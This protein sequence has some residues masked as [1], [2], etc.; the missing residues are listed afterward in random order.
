MKNFIRLSLISS[1]IILLF[2]QCGENR[3][4]DEPMER[5]SEPQEQTDLAF[6]K[7]WETPEELTTCESV[8]FDENSGA[9]Y[10]ANINGDPSEKNGSGFI[11]K[12]SKEGE[13]LEHEWVSGLD[14]PKGMGILEGQ[15]YVTDID[16]VVQVDIASASISNTWT[17]EGAV[18]LNDL[19]VSNGKVYF[20][21]SSAGTIFVLDDGE[22]NTFA[23]G[24]EGINGLKADSD[25]NLYGLD[26]EG[27]K[28]YSSDGSSEI[29]NNVVTGGDG[30]IILDE[31]KGDF[32][33][34]RWQGE[35]WIIL[36]NDS[37]KLLDTKE[38]ESNTADIGYIPEDHL[39][40]V[41]TFF[42]NKVVAYR[43]DY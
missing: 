41:P 38:E 36:G 24:Q 25:G 39:I 10:V 28:K 20:S 13:I 15:L 27:L 35:I 37:V 9:I 26:N 19:D 40:I 34:S 32:L 14:A 3:N 21:D 1:L 42:K 4:T 5:T 22:I 18:F 31:N 23:E 8:L 7:L 33:V 17:V 11:S 16:K 30:L 6:T 29:I 43:L 2:W 12:I